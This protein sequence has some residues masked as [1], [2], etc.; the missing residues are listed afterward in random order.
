VDGVR[1]LLLA[2]PG[3]TGVPRLEVLIVGPRTWLITGEV[4]IDGS[5]PNKDVTRLVGDLRGRL[6]TEPGVAEAYLTPV[7][8]GRG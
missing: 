8:D 7:A 4:A 5:W 6:R 3:V 2:E 1:R